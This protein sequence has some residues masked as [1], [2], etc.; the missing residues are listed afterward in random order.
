MNQLTGV[1]HEGLAPEKKSNAQ[2]VEGTNVLRNTLSHSLLAQQRIC[3]HIRLLETACVQTTPS[4]Q[5]GA[6]RGLSRS[7]QT[8]LSC[9]HIRYPFV[10]CI[11]MFVG[12]ICR[13]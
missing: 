2:R 11:Y 13:R 4:V 3:I 8:L 1:W 6:V 9:M 12:Q 10:S 7:A 5:G